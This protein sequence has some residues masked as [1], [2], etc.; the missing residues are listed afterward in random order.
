MVKGAIWMLLFKAATRGVGLVSMV[1]LARLLTPFD[2]G[3]V[4]LATAI[5]GAL[6]LMTAFSFDVPLIQNQQASRSQ[7]DTAWTISIVFAI[8]ISLFLVVVAPFAADFYG[9]PRL[10]LI[11]YVLA[12]GTFVE[13]FQNIGIVSFRKDMEFHKEFNFQVAKK[14]LGFVVTIFLAFTYRNYWALVAGIVFGKIGGTALSYLLSPYRPRFSMTAWSEL[15]GF[16]KWLVLNNILYFLR[17]RFADFTVGKMVGPSGLGIYALSYELSHLPTT[18]LVAPI[19]RAVFPGYS[20]MSED[21]SRLRQ[22]YL[23]V[24]SLIAL[25]ALPA[26][27]GVV[28][29]SEPI[30]LVVLGEKWA[31]AIP[32]I[33]ILALSGAISAM[34]TNIGPVY[35]ALG[36][37]QILTGLSALF[38]GILIPLMFVFTSKWGIYGTAWA[39]FVASAVTMPVYYL[40][41]FRTLS[42]PVMDFVA[43]VWRPLVASA[44][45]YL[46]IILLLPVIGSGGMDLPM[47]FI[48]FAMILLGAGFYF[49]VVI[50]LWRLSGAPSGAERNMLTRMSEMI[51]ARK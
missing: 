4:A 16:S 17:H 5:I 19:N 29:L 22:S 20:K 21:M 24:L 15:F 42:L 43:S 44:L 11:M 28:A 39:C 9:D 23:D 12:V 36:K 34:E 7:Y 6:E 1:I 45:M 47:F 41:M 37:P 2:F 51:A 3:L 31:E 49:G 32:L 25:F 26:A 40:T 50:V 18:E 10:K 8:F 33:P 46:S 35:L 13:G 14:L 27:I 38:V 48:L 30:V